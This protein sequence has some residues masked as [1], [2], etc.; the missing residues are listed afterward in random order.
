MFQVGNRLRFALE[1]LDRVHIVRQVA[2]DGFD[3]DRAVQ[4]LVARRPNIRHAAAP[5]VLDHA[6]M[7][8]LYTDIHISNPQRNY[9][10]FQ[11]YSVF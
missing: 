1:E 9:A 6:V 2:G 7:T 4:A 8:E 11:V 10:V 3:R 5:D